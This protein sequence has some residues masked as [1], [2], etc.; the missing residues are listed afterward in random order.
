MKWVKLGEI[1][2]IRMGKT[3]ARD[4]LKYWIAGNNTW[5]SISDMCEKFIFES[6]ENITGLAVEECNMKVVPKGTV[7]MSFKLSIGKRAITGKDLYTNEAIASFNIYDEKLITKEYLYYVLG[8]VD[9][10]SYVN[11][12]AK[13][14]TL[15][16]Q[17]LNIIK[18]PLL[19]LKDQEK[20]VEILDYAQALVDKQKEEI[21]LYNK[22]IESIFYEMF[23]DPLI[24]DCKWGR[25]KL[26]DI[27]SK[28]GSGA[29][30]RGGE[31][32]YKSEGI[33]L[34]RSMNVYDDGFLYDGLAFID[35]KQARDLNNV[36][37]EKGDILFNITGASIMRTC[38]VPE[39]ILP[40]RVNQ[41]V[42]IIRTTKEVNSN[43]LANLLKNKSYKRKLY[44]IATA[45]GAT[46]E[47]ITKGDL[48]ELDIPLPP[49][50]LQESFANKVKLIEEQKRILEKSLEEKETLFAAL[51]DR[52][53][54]GE[55][56]S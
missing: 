35:D 32:A 37:V 42:S 14:K 48:E 18:I 46:R 7:I 12:A 45:G 20:I 23:G 36:V 5:V 44:N 49:L 54:K 24:E 11:R 25:A 31:E 50:S 38:I 33:S 51:M 41:H 28:I 10:F 55:L 34:I 30:P 13:G 52:A 47:A 16:K 43:Y 22:L 15:N 2:E 19:T 1:A 29:T 8:Y 56:T 21:E 26:I 27:T 39:N 6:K 53:F 17:I 3:P 4:E 40:A 9:L